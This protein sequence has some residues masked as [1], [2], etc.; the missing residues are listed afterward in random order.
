MIRH[1]CEIC[2][3]HSDA[4]LRTMSH[5]IQRVSFP[6]LLFCEPTMTYFGSSLLHHVWNSWMQMWDDLQ[7]AVTAL[8]L[9]KCSIKLSHCTH[10]RRHCTLTVKCHFSWMKFLS[11][12]IGQAKAADGLYFWLEVISFKFVWASEESLLSLMGVFNLLW[13]SDLTGFV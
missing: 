7:L 4:V 9:S 10:Q 2:F 11:L 3:G 1:A 8:I 12:M 13:L 6:W 5:S